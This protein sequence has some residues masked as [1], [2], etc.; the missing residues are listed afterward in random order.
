MKW[1]IRTCAE[2]FK[3]VKL[4]GNT[5]YLRRSCQWPP[6][7]PERGP[8]YD[9]NYKGCVIALI[10]LEGKGARVSALKACRCFPEISD[11]DLAEMALR[12]VRFRKAA[13]D[14][15]N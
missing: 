13:A 8:A 4:S 12:L 1:D 6:D 5:A 2:G 15:L 9:V 11:L 7:A 14:A 10:S 3:A